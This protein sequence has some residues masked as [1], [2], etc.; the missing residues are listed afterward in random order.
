MRTVSPGESGDG[1]TT[2]RSPT[3][4]PASAARRSSTAM[5]RSGACRAKARKRRVNMSVEWTSAD[6]P[7]DGTSALG[8]PAGFARRA[9]GRSVSGGTLMTVASCHRRARFVPGFTH[10]LDRLLQF[11][12]RLLERV[13]RLAECGHAFL[14]QPEP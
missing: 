8:H 3:R 2:T 12:A 5:V 7:I 14:H 9:G 6:A 11:G 1:A 13:R 10:P 4:S